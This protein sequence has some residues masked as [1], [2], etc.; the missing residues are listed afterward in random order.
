MKRPTALTIVAVLM[1]L[2]GLA[3]VV[4]DCWRSHGFVAPSS[5]FLNMIAGVGL[6]KHSRI[7]RIYSLLMT[8]AVTVCSVLGFYVASAPDN[9]VPHHIRFSGDYGFDFVV[10]N[11]MVIPL[12]FAVCAVVSGW[13]FYV[14]K[15]SEVRELFA[16][17]TAVANSVSTF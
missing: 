4:S 10:Q 11:P 13:M 15:R 7:A 3:G 5:S 9:I 16:K 8:F 17:K 12:L 2:T 14:L 1:F 6:L